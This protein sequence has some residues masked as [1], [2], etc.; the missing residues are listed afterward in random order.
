[1]T[2]I[3]PVLNFTMTDIDGQ[4][5]ELKRYLGSVVMIV[6]VASKCGFTAQYRQLED[7]YLKEQARGLVILGFPANNFLFQEPGTNP[8]I[9]AFCQLRY[10]VSFPLFAK[11]SVRGKDIVP[12]YQILTTAATKPV[13]AGKITW[14]FNKFILNRAG[15]P[16]YR[17]G[18]RTEPQ[19]PTVLQTIAELL[20]EPI[21][22]VALDTIDKRQ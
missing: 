6:N 15:Q 17:F 4:P 2:M 16:I 11:I 14:N 5:M 3:P 1:M 10:N 7:L 21:P 20:A 12:L 9:K 8:E 19:D 22:D 13:A 18:S